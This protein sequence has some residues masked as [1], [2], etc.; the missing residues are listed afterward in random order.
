MRKIRFK[1][2]KIAMNVC[3]FIANLYERFGCPYKATN[4]RLKSINFGLQY[5][6]KCR[7]DF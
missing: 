2:C 6:K 1:Y 4:W 7:R 5:L 3:G